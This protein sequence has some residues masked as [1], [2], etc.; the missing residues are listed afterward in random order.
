MISLMATRVHHDKIARFIVGD[1]VIEM[2]HVS[3]TWSFPN[4]QHRLITLVT[5]PWC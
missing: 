1:V 2:M 3:I 4:L 5:T